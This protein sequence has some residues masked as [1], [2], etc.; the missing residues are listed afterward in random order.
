MALGVVDANAFAHVDVCGDGVRLRRKP[1]VGQ[2]LA[3]EQRVPRGVQPVLRPGQRQPLAQLAGAVEEVLSLVGGQFDRALAKAQVGD[4]LLIPAG[5]SPR[6]STAAG[7]PSAS[8]TRFRQ[9]CIP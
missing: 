2:G 7:S 5:V 4:D 9:W 3:H 8:V 1:Q 6:S